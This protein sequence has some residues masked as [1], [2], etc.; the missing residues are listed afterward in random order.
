MVELETF[1]LFI[2]VP[3]QSTARLEEYLR[4]RS[5]PIVARIAED[6]LVFDPRTL[7]A[8]EY[9]EIGCACQELLSL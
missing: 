3:G 8:D 9:A 2:R 4:G 1:A 5:Q 7:F 6:W